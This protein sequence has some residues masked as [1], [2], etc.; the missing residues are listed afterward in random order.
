MDQSCCG[1]PVQ[2]M[3]ERNASRSVAEQNVNAFDPAAYDY[4][5]TLCASCASHLKHGYPDI[6]AGDRKLDIKVRQFAD[7]V[8]DFSSF[9]H[10]VLKVTPEEFHPDGKKVTYHSPCHLCR[11]LN[12]TQAPRELM[13]TG[14]MDYLPA[15]EEDVC[16]G[17]GG[18]YSMKFPELSAELLKKKLANVEKT[19]AELLLTD[20][21]GCIMQLRGGLEAKGSSVKVGHIAEALAERLK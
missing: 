12:V 2:M 1:L 10:D 3:G 21:P 13:A 19:G 11:G 18:T 9:V 20:C 16:C 7:R 8:I 14:G 6:L 15:D 17:F 5:L 4:I